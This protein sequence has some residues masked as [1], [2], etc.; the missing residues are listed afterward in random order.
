MGIEFCYVLF[1]A[2]AEMIIWVFF[3]WSVVM[4]HYFLMSSNLIFL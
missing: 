2:S 4:V 3:V 1:F